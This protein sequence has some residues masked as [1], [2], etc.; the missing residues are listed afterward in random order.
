MNGCKTDKTPE[1]PETPI[2]VEAQDLTTQDPITTAPPTKF[3]QKPAPGTIS[4]HS[5]NSKEGAQV[6]QSSLVLRAS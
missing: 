6:T 3:L 5:L 1:L 2:F 4:H